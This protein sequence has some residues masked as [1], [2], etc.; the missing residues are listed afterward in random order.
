MGTLDDPTQGELNQKKLREDQ[1]AEILEENIP[2]EHLKKY[3]KSK[4]ARLL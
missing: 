1:W 2:S 4:N 3:L